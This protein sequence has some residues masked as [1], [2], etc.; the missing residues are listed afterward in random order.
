MWIILIVAIAAFLGF[1]LWLGY[2]VPLVKRAPAEA[3]AQSWSSSSGKNSSLSPILVRR[4]LL[5]K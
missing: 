3:D 4:E 1:I 2:E 5:P